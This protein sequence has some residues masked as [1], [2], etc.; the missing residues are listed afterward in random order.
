MHIHH[1]SFPIQSLAV[2]I[3]ECLTDGVAKNVLRKVVSTLRFCSKISSAIYLE[4]ILCWKIVELIFH[5]IRAG[6]RYKLNAYAL[7]LPW[8]K[9]KQNI[10]EYREL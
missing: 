7:M 1:I 2:S 3:M 10:V 5:C 8:E 9:H 4:F 6:T